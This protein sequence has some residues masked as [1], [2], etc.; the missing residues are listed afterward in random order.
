M[1]R[2]KQRFDRDGTRAW[3]VSSSGSIAIERGYERARFWTEP[4]TY[5]ATSLG[6]CTHDRRR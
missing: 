5:A 3:N 6:R 4:A 1:E 2:V